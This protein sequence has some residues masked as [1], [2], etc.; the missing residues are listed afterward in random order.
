MPIEVTDAPKNQRNNVN[1]TALIPL[2]KEHEQ[3]RAGG[4][5]SEPSQIPK[6]S[7]P[8]VASRHLGA[9]SD[10]SSFT[11]ASVFSTSPNRRKAAFPLHS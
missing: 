6:S 5:E 9:H 11:W 10:T 2:M 1:N 4:A 8:A 3:S 7:V